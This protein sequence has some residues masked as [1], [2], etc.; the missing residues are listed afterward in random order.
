ML[1]SWYHTIFNSY[2]KEISLL[3]KDLYVKIYEMT[4][5]DETLSYKI[6]D[7]ENEISSFIDKIKNICI[8]TF[9]YIL[10]NIVQDKI[11]K[12]FQNSYK[13]LGINLFIVNE[14]KLTINTRLGPCVFNRK[15]L[16][17]KCEIQK[18]ALEQYENTKT[19]SPLDTLIREKKYTFKV[20][21][22]LMIEI[23][24][25][26]VVSC[27]YQKAH[28]FITRNFKVDISKEKMRNITNFIG[29]IVFD[30]NTQKANESINIY[31]KFGS[32]SKKGYVMFQMDGSFGLI[33]GDG[34][35]TTEW[36]EIKLGLITTSDDLIEYKDASGNNKIKMGKREY[37]CYLG[38]YDE[39][40]KYLLYLYVKNKCYEYDV[41][42][43][44]GDGAKWIKNFK[45]EFFPN[46]ILILDFYHLS[47][48]VNDFTKSVFDNDK[49][50]KKN[51][52]TICE[53]LK[54]SRTSEA[55][56]LI[57]ELGSGKAQKNATA[58]EQYINNNIDSI[59]YAY[60]ISQNY[61]IGSGAIESG[62][63]LVT[64][65]RV[66]LAGMRW[67]QENINNILS[68]KALEASDKWNDVIDIFCAFIF[69]KNKI[70][71]T[72]FDIS[73]CNK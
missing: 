18:K 52:V 61:F 57:K 24:Y 12:I 62:N 17:P 4:Y 72:F 59:D 49:D 73:D 44:I 20:S 48:H 38:K 3:Y 1:N 43:I 31:D 68:L 54:Q 7:I 8:K 67:M 33:W 16:Q 29:K 28:T 5:Y 11:I 23:A 45:K 63:K 56:S 71:N 6:T 69:N 58:L 46:A 34:K 42:L 26:S 55:I 22:I 30:Y 51:A 47:E 25:Y 15:K 65:S 50:A 64:Q 13:K 32:H 41:V 27:S 53:L 9:V 35:E 21:H 70:I 2:Q 10:E 14:K 39:F 66:K 37:I 40:K 19:L 60:Y 36:R